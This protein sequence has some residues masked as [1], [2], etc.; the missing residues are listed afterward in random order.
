[1]PEVPG[2]ASTIGEI[3]FPNLV[4]APSRSAVDAVRFSSDGKPLLAAIQAAPTQSA[5]K[6]VAMT[7]RT[8]IAPRTDRLV[9]F[10]LKTA[11]ASGKRYK[12]APRRTGLPMLSLMLVRQLLN[13]LICAQQ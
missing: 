13:H 8:F 1:M 4:S 3:A 5:R 6:Q 2:C 10:T 11:A 9:S 7:V 12:R